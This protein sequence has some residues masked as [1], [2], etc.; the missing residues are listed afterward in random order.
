MDADDD[1]YDALI[2][3]ICKE[4]SQLA[5]AKAAEEKEAKEGVEEAKEVAVTAEG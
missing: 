1:A 4:T 3:Q 2:S 5:L